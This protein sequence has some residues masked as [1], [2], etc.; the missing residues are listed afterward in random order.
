V[1]SVRKRAKKIGCPAK[2]TVRRW[3]EEED[4]IILASTGKHLNEVAKELNRDPSDLSKRARKLGIKFWRRPYGDQ[5]IDSH[6]YAVES[7]EKGKVI[8][9]YRGNLP[10][11]KRIVESQ[12]GD[13]AVDD[14]GHLIQMGMGGP[15]EL[16]NQVPMEK[17]LN[18]SNAKLWRKVEQYEEKEGWEKGKKVI[19]KRK[20]IYKGN[21]PRPSEIEIDVIV[22]GKHAV[23][24]GKQCPFTIQNL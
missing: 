1:K 15:N 9:R 5:Y 6:G 24:D 14:G 19:T 12:G 23:I 16:I 20:P 11:Q 22:D 8:Q 10:E 18:E 3:S 4:N 7:F 17:T 13:I 21:S 2:K